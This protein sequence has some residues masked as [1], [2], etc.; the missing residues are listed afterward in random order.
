M[1]P[2][3]TGTINLHWSAALLAGLVDAGM[4]RIVISPGSRNTPLTLAADL[5]PGLTCHVQVDER[6]AAFFAMGMAKASGKPV[7]LQCTSGTAAANWFPAVVEASQSGIPLILLTADRPWELQQCG[8]NQ[9]IDQ[10]KLFGSHVRAFHQLSEA[11]GS[12]KALRRVRQLAVQVVQESLWL[13]PGPVHVNM[14][15][16]EPLLPLGTITPVGLP[17]RSPLSAPY[18]VPTLHPSTSQMTTIRDSISGKPGLIMCGEGDYSEAFPAA[19]MQLAEALDTPVVADPLANLRFGEHVSRHLLS[20]YDAFLRDTTFT[21]TYLPQWVLHFGNMP[22]SRALQQYLAACQPALTV[23]VDGRG[24]W[25]DPLARDILM[26]RAAPDTVCQQ[27]A[28][29][30]P[31][32]APASWLDCFVQAEQENGAVLEADLRAEACIIRQMLS[33]L[34]EGSLLFSGNSMPIRLIDRYSGKGTKRLIVAAN[35][36][37]SGIDGNISTLL[38]MATVH[39]GKTVALLGDLTFFHDM[40]GLLLAKEANVVIVLLNNNGGGIFHMLPQARLEAAQF[41][42][43]WLTPTGLDFSL[44][45]QM[46]G[47]GFSR[48]KGASGFVAAFGHALQQ[49][50]T[51]VIEVML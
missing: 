5:T 38:G 37:A 32:P 2:T 27:L 44:A 19:L 1:Q 23:V 25:P 28:A 30:N 49:E 18:P 33:N 40:N 11:E 10:G 13:K 36:G 35:R 29:L 14:P 21:D 24:G 46:Y 31:L 41:E 4:E 51:S 12:E 8:A 3:D 17:G 9:T 16:R 42:R 47:L 48:V 26:V 20:R 43:Y 34:P 6:S 15:L 7:A 39:P 45:A 22:V 50:R